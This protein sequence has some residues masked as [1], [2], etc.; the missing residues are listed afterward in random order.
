MDTSAESIV[1]YIDR[2]TS[3][4]RARIADPDLAQDAVQEAITKAVQAS[5]QLRDGDKLLPWL[6]AI[7][8]NT[9][10]DLQRRQAR[11]IPV[12]GIGDALPAPDAEEADTICACF[13]PLLSTLPSD[14]GELLRRVDL[15][16]ET[17][18]AVAGELQ[19]STGNLNV[20]LHRAREKLRQA[21][22]NTCQM[23][24]RHG[25]LNCTCAQ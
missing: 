17:R 14:Y 19:I 3:Y 18:E 4:A 1:S 15:G 12:E 9:I 16:G 20:R 2:L 25:C 22:E 21:I 13:Q 7:L 6:Y 11:E 10:A 5:A 8:R 24:A 23:C